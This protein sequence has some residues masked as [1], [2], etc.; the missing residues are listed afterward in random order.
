M[1]RNGAEGLGTA[2]WK[3]PA[4]KNEFTEMV[5]GLQRLAR[6]QAGWDPYEVWRTRVRGA[7]TVM[8]ERKRDRLR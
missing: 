3:L 4:A 8:Q 1:K 6:P 5:N 7:S 2:Y